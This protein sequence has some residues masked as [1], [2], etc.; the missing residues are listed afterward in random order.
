MSTQS[1]LLGVLQNLEITRLGS[2]KLIPVDIRLITANNKNPEVLVHQNLFREDLLFRINTI[3]IELPPLR[4]RKE[5]IPGLADYYLS[6]YANKYEKPSLKMSGATYN[7]L[8]NYHWSGNIRELKHTIEKAVILCDSTI[9]KPGDLNLKERTTLK[10][11]EESLY[12]LSDIEKGAIIRVLEKCQGNV[13]KAAYM[14]DI[15]RTT[16]YSKMKEYKI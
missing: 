3:Q 2:S 1:K 7:A 4:E 6:Q 5:D 14:L 16:L 9:L 12:S 15:S 13:S 10:N 8:V 11:E